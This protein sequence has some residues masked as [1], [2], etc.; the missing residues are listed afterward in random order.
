MLD[1]NKQ[2]KQSTVL[3]VADMHNMR[4]VE[5]RA[6]LEMRIKSLQSDVRTVKAELPNEQ[7][8]GLIIRQARLREVLNRRE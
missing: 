7:V 4:N 3:E 1:T 2:I 5:D 8:V 6:D